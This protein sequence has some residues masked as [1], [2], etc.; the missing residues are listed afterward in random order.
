M[1][2]TWLRIISRQE[3]KNPILSCSNK[4]Y[5]VKRIKKK[6]L[7]CYKI[8]NADYIEMHAFYPHSPENKYVQYEKNTC[9]LSSLDSDFFAANEHV[10]EHY[11]GSRL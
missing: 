6:R 9:V 1:L 5:L 10:A 4:T 2:I 8:G 11:F 7:S 3:K